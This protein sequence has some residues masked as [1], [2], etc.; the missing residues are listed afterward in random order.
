MAGFFAPMMKLFKKRNADV[1]VMDISRGLG[2]KEKF[3]EKLENW[4]DVLIL[5]STS[6]LNNTTEEVLEHVGETVKTVM[7]GPSTPMV[8]EAFENLPVHMLAGM[9]PVE[10]ENVLKAVRHGMGT[11]VIQKFSKKSFLDFF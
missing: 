2:W 8:R 7:L 11:P 10:K 9:V 1:E 4:A 3:Y 6:V 5:T